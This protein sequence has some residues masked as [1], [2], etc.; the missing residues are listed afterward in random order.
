MNMKVSFDRA[1]S[2]IQGWY[3]GYCR[4]TGTIPTTLEI[5]EEDDRVSNAYKLTNPCNGK[6]SPFYYNYVNEYEILGSVGIPG[7]LKTGVWETFHDLN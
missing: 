3:Q 4:E 6:T 5:L 1:K 2:V 7:D